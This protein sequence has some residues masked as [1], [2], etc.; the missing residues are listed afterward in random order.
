VELDP[1]LDRPGAGGQLARRPAAKLL[2]CPP[3]VLERR[4]AIVAGEHP[5]E[6]EAH[7]GGEQLRDRSVRG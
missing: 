3:R 2:E 5:R 6:L 7:V 1:I 4:L